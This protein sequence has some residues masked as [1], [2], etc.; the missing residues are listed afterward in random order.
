[1]LASGQQYAATAWWLAAWP[2]LAI[3]LLSLSLI[4]LGNWLRDVY[5]PRSE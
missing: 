2:G 3:T 5:D 4:F 1:M